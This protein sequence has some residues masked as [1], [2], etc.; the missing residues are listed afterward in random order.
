MDETDALVAAPPRWA[1]PSGHAS[2]QMAWRAGSPPGVADLAATREN[3]PRQ[4][5]MVL[6]DGVTARVVEWFAEDNPEDLTRSEPDGADAPGL[7]SIV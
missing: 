7:Q 1:S 3:P 5:G 2:A 4:R 6:V